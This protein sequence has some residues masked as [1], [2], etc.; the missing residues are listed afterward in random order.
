M[1]REKENR[2]RK[3]VPFPALEKE[4]CQEKAEQLLP[5]KA[6]Q[7]FAELEQVNGIFLVS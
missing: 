6:L 7:R 5:L 1:R 3:P 2:K 4:G